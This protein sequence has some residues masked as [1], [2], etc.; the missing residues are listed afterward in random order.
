MKVTKNVRVTKSLKV[1]EIIRLS[2][3]VPSVEK[4]EKN[5]SFARAYARGILNNLMV[6][7][8]ENGL[9]VL[10]DLETKQ[11]HEVNVKYNVEFSVVDFFTKELSKLAKETPF[12][13]N[14]RRLEKRNYTNVKFEVFKGFQATKVDEIVFVNGIATL[15]MDN[16]QQ[17]ILVD[18][19]YSEKFELSLR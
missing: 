7:S 3:S 13:F 2:V 9:I 1:G 15:T 17:M 4:N 11:I 8:I 19:K 10:K 18:K 14:Y 12:S 5:R 6:E 16:I